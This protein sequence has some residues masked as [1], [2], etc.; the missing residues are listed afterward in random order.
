[1]ED[2]SKLRADV[3][4]EIFHMGITSIQGFHIIDGMKS[5]FEA[6]AASKTPPR[7][8]AAELIWLWAT[9]LATSAETVY[10]QS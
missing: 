7:K 9:G 3:S 1:M 10:N 2:Y 8:I 4:A 5:T 6:R